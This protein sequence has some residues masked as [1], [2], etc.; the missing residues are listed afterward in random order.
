MIT[1]QEEALADCL[2]EMKPLLESHWEE[3]AIH[4]EVVKLDPDYDKYLLLDNMGMLHVLTV[5]DE[6]VLIGY[7]ISFIQPHMH[8]KS[9]IYAVNDILYLDK[10]YRKGL[11]GY[12]MFK[13]AEEL[14][15]EIGVDVIVIHSKVN[16]DF[17][18]LMDKLGFNMVENTYSKFVGVV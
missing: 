12:K 2:E 16:K 13:R 4:K 8:Y 5:R 17:K 18:S 15:T 11:T 14:L 10:E 3:I 1:Y 6:G 9:T 7:F